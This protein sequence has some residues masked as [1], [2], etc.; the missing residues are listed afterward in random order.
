MFRR[1][2]AIVPVFLLWTAGAARAQEW[3]A[4]TDPRI[5][6]MSILFRLA[7][8]SEYHQCRIPAYDKAIETYFVRYQNHQAVELARSLRTGFEGP[9]KMAVYLRDPDSL[10][11]LV[12]FDRAHLHLYEGWDP[13]KARNFLAAARQFCVDSK[14]ADFV[15]SQQALYHNVDV[16]LQ[17]ALRDK[18]DLD[19]FRRFF[20]SP[21]PA[22]F[23]IVPGLANGA[24]SYAAR[25][26]D[27]GGTQELYAIPGVQTVDTEGLPI[28]DAAWRLTM[29]HELAHMFTDPAA[30]KFAPQMEK[31]LR[32]I[33]TAAA[34]GMQRQSYNNWRTLL[35]QSLARAVGIEYVTEHDGPDAA[36]MVIRQD[37]SRSFFWM[38]G[39]V[40]VLD[41]YRNS[42]D[43]FP[44]FE[45]FMPR[46]VEYFIGLAPGIQGLVDRVQP[47]V[48]STSI[49]E[50]AQNVDPASKSIVV[51]FSMPM[52][53]VGP[54]ATAK[55]AGGRFDTAGTVLTIPVMLEPER[56]YAIPIRWSGGQAFLSVNGVPLPSTVLRFRT[57]PATAS[58]Q[59]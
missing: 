2:A 16:R 32:Q 51:R 4:G 14:F 39:L 56:D 37:Q 36:R 43:Q 31:S 10:A 53:R 49:A 50:G 35:N 11:E 48:V 15:K 6:M 42:R 44:T 25:V 34:E 12:P 5:E 54:G 19:W 46:V 23:V 18:G 9:M 59:P 26:V 30:A 40:K 27:D 22:L 1:A 41:S 3:R 47:K 55:A 52:N 17:A 58:K 29:V 45:S 8:N 20:A 33:Y 13:V 57:G 21:Q 7:G 24:P 38:P 28:F